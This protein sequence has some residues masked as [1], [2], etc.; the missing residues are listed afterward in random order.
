MFNKKYFCEDRHLQIVSIS[1]PY[2]GLVAKI[3]KTNKLMT[4]KVKQKPRSQDCNNSKYKFFCIF[5]V[6]ETYSQ[7]ASFHKQTET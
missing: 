2:T 5:D 7:V 1:F 4:D 3:L 6:I